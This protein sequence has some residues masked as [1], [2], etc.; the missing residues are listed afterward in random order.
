MGIY[1]LTVRVQDGKIAS[2]AVAA[3]VQGRVRASPARPEGLASCSPG[4]RRGLLSSS[5]GRL[6]PVMALQLREHEG[7]EGLHRRAV[8]SR[9]GA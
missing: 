9:R 3:A 8:R 7:S 6:S 5:P 2:A 4:G 1:L